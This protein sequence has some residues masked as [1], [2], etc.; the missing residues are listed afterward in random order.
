M[1]KLKKN[2]QNLN[3]INVDNI[4][5]DNINIDDE[6]EPNEIVT[7]INTLYNNTINSVNLTKFSRNKDGLFHINGN[8]YELLNGTRQEVWENKAYRTTG[9]LTKN[10]LLVNKCDKIVS[11]KKC[12]QEK[13]FN[14]FFKCGINKI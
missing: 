3:N 5:V 13:N 10:D 14:R 11:K 12:E 7:D 6:S 9:H 8:S 4:Y 2:N 1:S